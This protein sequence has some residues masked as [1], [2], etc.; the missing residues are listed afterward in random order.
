[1]VKRK[2]NKRIPKRSKLFGAPAATGLVMCDSRALRVGKTQIGEANQFAESVG[3]GAP[4]Q[5]DGHF[6]AS[7]SL[8]KRFL[9]E[10]NKRAADLGEPRFVN[11]DG[12][13]GDEI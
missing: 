13:Y 10:R 5:K 8:L 7:R 4:F 11:L 9:R 3:C 6:K 1:M 12:G 2:R